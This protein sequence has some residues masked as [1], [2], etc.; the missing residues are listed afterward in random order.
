MSATRRALLAGVVASA[1]ALAPAPAALAAAPARAPAFADEFDGAALDLTHWNFRA[2]GPRNDGILTPDAVSLGG[3]A[4]TIQTYTE[5][6][7]HFSG[8][9]STQQTGAAGFA[10]FQ[11]R[12]GYFE[13]RARFH[14]TTGQWSAFWLQSPTIGSPV[15]D[16]ATAGVEM[17]VAEY[18]ARRCVTVATATPPS[19]CAADADASDRIQQAMVWDGY[20]ADSRA[21]VNLSGPLGGLG[22]D[23]WHTWAVRWTPTDLTFYYDDA[24]TWSGTGPISQRS[25]Y[26]ILSSEVGAFFAGTI[27]PGGFGTRATSTTNMQ[28]D[29]VRAWTPAPP[30]NT[31]S[32][33]ASGTP[34]AGQPLACA[35]GA[36]AG[37]APSF[38]YEW[39]SDG[40][41]IAGASTPSYAVAATDQGHA[42]ACRVTAANDWGSGTAMSNAVAIPVPPPAPAPVAVAV[43]APRLAA[44]PLPPPAPPVVLDRTAP[45]A[46]LSG[47][48]SQRLGATV[49]VTVVC[50]LESCLAGASGSVR[51]P[52]TG[53]TSAR[54]YRAAGVTKALAQGSR[55]TLRPRFSHTARQA[56][57]RALRAHRRIV[58]KLAVAVTD[59]AGNV[60]RLSRQIVLRR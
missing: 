26:V 40:A 54:T 3:G 1:A 53:R 28:V 7:Q 45:D 13:I 2:S 23:T 15:G 29:Y 38:A 51:V 10:G 50:P 59:T 42:L 32:P 48:R 44:L 9:I 35:P 33:A 46:A 56:I 49:A 20:G 36:W 21:V 12:Y 19:V 55:A 47:S 43:P 16:P 39:L 5:G 31:T 60:R 17:D 41:P 52:R 34:A 18:R 22:N 37:D 25:Q 8:M 6:G 11:Q 14:S 58:V 27:P 4:L 30:Q 57:G 24:V